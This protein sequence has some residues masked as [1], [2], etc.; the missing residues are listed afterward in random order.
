MAV[1]ELETSGEL[2]VDNPEETAATKAAG[3]GKGTELEA[4]GVDTVT[5]ACAAGAGEIGEEGVAV[6]VDGASANSEEEA[7]GMAG[8]EEKGLEIDGCEKAKE[9]A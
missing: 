3:D 5:D 4:V 1:N 6:E 2:V 8:S 7:G 9:G